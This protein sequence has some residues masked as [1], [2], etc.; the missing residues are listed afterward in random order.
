MGCTDG[1]IGCSPNEHPAHEVTLSRAFWISETEVTQSE[2]QALMGTNPSYFSGCTDCPVEKVNWFEA[3]AYANALSVSEGLA[4][5]FD[6]SGVE[7]G[8]TVTVLSTSGN[9]YDC[10]GYRLPTEAEWEY[11]ARAGTDFI[12][13]GS[14]IVNSV[15]WFGDGVFT[16]TVNETK[17]VATK[18]ANSWGIHDMSG[19]VWEWCWDWYGEDYYS[20]TSAI[21]PLGP[22]N[23]D[24]SEYY[25]LPTRIMR[26]GSWSEGGTN[27]GAHRVSCRG[28]A[29][30][31]NK[32]QYIG[33]RLVR[34]AL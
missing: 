31:S 12:Y 10:E 7:E 28:E 18:S 13:S 20:Q 16:P 6:I 25:A 1:Q 34:T 11:A 19:N 8:S 32:S 21:D 9:P 26:G 2:Y 14:D 29:L 33:F 27:S 24:I 30:G 4:P 22:I 3:L 23:G 15:A 5:C 17:P